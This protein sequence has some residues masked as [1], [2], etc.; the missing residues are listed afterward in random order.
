ME[1][2]AN[3]GLNID[4]DETPSS[5]LVYAY[6]RRYAFRSVAHRLFGWPV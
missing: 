2:L 3:T 6:E 4:V 1:S 5:F